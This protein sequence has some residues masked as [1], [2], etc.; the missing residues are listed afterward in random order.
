M[1]KTL[2]VFLV[3]VLAGCLAIII[4]TNITPI[5]ADINNYLSLLPEVNLSMDETLLEKRLDGFDDPKNFISY[6]K[7][8]GGILGLLYPVDVKYI[9]EE[10][11]LKDKSNKIYDSNSS[12][13]KYQ[14]IHN[15]ILSYFSENINN[16][17]QQ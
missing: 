1:K 12:K 17:Y 7:T 11:N 4:I 15:D 8:D 5:R 10:G 14:T 2:I 6:K 16:G 9:D 13:F 3:L